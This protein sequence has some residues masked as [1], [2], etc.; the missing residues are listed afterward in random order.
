M[1]DLQEQPWHGS[2]AVLASRS[3][4]RSSSGIGLLGKVNAIV[5]IG[6]FEIESRCGEIGEIVVSRLK[7]TRYLDIPA[8]LG[9][10][11]GNFICSISTK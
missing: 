1:L 5:C 10:E 11:V 4:S 9:N 6:S 2:T 7:K 3:P 8:L